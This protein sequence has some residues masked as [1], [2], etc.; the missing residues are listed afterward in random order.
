MRKFIFTSGS[1]LIIL[2]LFI[3]GKPRLERQGS[4]QTTGVTNE[5]GLKDYYKD[6]FPIGVAVTSKIQGEEAALVLQQF[7]S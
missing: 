2:T 7:N 4:I 3:Q 1:F 6:Y 5:K